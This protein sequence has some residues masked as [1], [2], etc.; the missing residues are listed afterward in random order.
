MVS[1]AP[2]EISSWAT[3]FLRISIECSLSHLLASLLLFSLIKRLQLLRKSRIRQLIQHRVSTHQ[4]N[5]L[6]SILFV[7]FQV[8]PC[9]ITTDS[10]LDLLMHKLSDPFW[11][12][13]TA[14]GL[15]MSNSKKA[16]FDNCQTIESLVWEVGIKSKYIIFN[17][18]TEQES[19][20][21]KEQQNF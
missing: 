1:Q 20:E 9:F 15:D 13:S 18:H 3:I 14:K 4:I 7:Q 10:S 19:S 6:I 12:R 21:R 2:F 11:R 5:R 17:R 8:L 16:Q